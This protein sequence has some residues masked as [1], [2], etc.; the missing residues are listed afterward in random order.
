MNGFIFH[1]NVIYTTAVHTLSYDYSTPKP[2]GLHLHVWFGYAFF[3][4]AA[5]SMIAQKKRKK[6]TKNIP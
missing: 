4:F 1:Y 2:D 5:A 6:Q 3:I